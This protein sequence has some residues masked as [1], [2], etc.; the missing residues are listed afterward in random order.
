MAKRKTEISVGEYYHLYNRGV[1]KDR[2]FH[3][4]EDYERYLLIL[5]LANCRASFNLYDLQRSKA[6]ETFISNNQDDF[7]V[8]IGAYVLMPNHF[9]ILVKEVKNKGVSEFM[10]KVSTAYAMYF[11]RK[12]QRSGALFESR[13]KSRHVN[14]DEYLKYLYAYIYMNPLKLKDKDWKT[15]A[16]FHKKEYMEFLRGY[17]YSSFHREDRPHGENYFP[18]YFKESGLVNIE[19]HVQ[20]WIEIYIDADE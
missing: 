20:E 12:Y 3:D 1:N 5:K 10:K 4:K 14:K 15:N 18:E 19:K 8:A 7:L 6:V 16:K 17:K 9:H 2:I 13:F 11:N